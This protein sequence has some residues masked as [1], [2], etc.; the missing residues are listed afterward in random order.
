MSEI[1]LALLA[2]EKL[3]NLIYEN[4]DTQ[5][6]FAYDYGLDLR[7]VNRYINVGITKVTTIQELSEFFNVDY[8]YF[9]SK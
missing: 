3:R 7:S 6:D 1:N 9:F 2:G 4:Y 5:E 8:S